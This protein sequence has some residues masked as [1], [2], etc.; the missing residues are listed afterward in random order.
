MAEAQHRARTFRGQSD[1]DN[2]GTWRHRVMVFP[3]PCHQYSVRR[4]KLP[5][6]ANGDVFPVDVDAVPPARSRIKFRSYAHPGRELVRLGQV[7]EDDRGRGGNPL[8]QI[9]VRASFDQLFDRFLSS[10]SASRRRRSVFRVHI[11]R[12]YCSSGR[13]ACLSAL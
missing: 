9:D 12:R 6:L 5:I 10:V 3:A 2:G 13:S 1:L 4:V 8:R 7:G 11:W